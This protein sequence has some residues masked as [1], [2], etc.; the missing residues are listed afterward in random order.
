MTL[1]T[2]KTTMKKLLLRLLWLF[3]FF[4]FIGRTI[5]HCF[6]RLY[7]HIDRTQNLMYF[8]K[9]KMTDSFIFSVLRALK[10]EAKQT[11]ARRN[12]K[13]LYDSRQRSEEKESSSTVC[14]LQELLG[15]QIRSLKFNLTQRLKT[16]KILTKIEEQFIEIV[17]LRTD[18]QC[19][20]VVTYTYIEWR[21]RWV[22]NNEWERL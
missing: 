5:F 1:N 6:K 22:A 21:W 3:Y 11:E 19:G 15:C 13:K 18:R 4:V 9:H 14:C 20:F 12:K 8:N 10:S 7:L 2:T 17:R 16:I